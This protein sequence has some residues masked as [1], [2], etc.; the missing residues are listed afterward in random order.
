MRT[1][2]GIGDSAPD[3]TLP[4]AGSGELLT[5]S[6]FGG[7]KILLSF[8]Q[9]ANCPC[10]HYAVEQ[11]IGAHKKLAWAAK[12]HV[13]CVFQSDAN[14][15]KKYI[16]KRGADDDND[17]KAGEYI[18]P[19]VALS[20]IEEHAY[21]LYEV[22][23][24]GGMRNLKSSIARSNRRLPTEV[25]LERG[26]PTRLPT[27]FLID[28]TGMI[29]DC[30]RAKTVADHMPMQSIE[31][32]LMT[33][34]NSLGTTIKLRAGACA[35]DFTLCDVDGK[36]YSLSQYHGQKVMLSFYRYAGCPCCRRAIEKLKKF[37]K[38]LSRSGAEKI[39]ILCIYPSAPESI[40]ECILRDS[41]PSDFPFI[42]LSD[43]GEKLYKKYRVGADTSGHHAIS[44]A[45]IWYKLAFKGFAGREPEGGNIRLP[46]D[47]LIDE[48]GMIADCFHARSAYEHIP[49][50]RVEQFM[51]RTASLKQSTEPE[52]ELRATVF[53]RIRRSS[54]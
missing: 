49:L 35:P 41:G 2:I 33:G 3:F 16:L 10:C 34:G 39:N 53:D 13:I 28:E 22:G 45:T 24:V 27:D 31:H 26:T 19:F 14:T 18:F 32:F 1:R 7:K 54:A 21:D 51:K 11:L 47:F 15:I 43:P 46:S 12:L 30:F 44:V 20:G 8:H 23:V 29:V 50:K 40:K 17:N 48:N 37:N 42:A 6:H 36:P 5:F 38:R 25:E 9:D 4:S 52:D